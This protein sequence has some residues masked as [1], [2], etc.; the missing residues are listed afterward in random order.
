MVHASRRKPPSMKRN[1]IFHATRRR[2]QRQL[3]IGCHFSRAVSGLS[4]TVMPASTEGDRE[5]QG[6]NGPCSRRRFRRWPLPASSGQPTRVPPRTPSGRLRLFVTVRNRRRSSIPRPSAPL[7]A[8]CLLRAL[9]RSARPAPGNISSALTPVVTSVGSRGRG[10][11]EMADCGPWGR[12][13]QRHSSLHCGLPRL[14]SGR[15]ASVRL[16][17]ADSGWGGPS[18]ATAPGRCDAP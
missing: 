5:R 3:S 7:L 11:W 4:A 16:R 9:R 18:G 8:E 6:S 10:R 14:R 13:D 2:R 12:R 15:A 17:S 1:R